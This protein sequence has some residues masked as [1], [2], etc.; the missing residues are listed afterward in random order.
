MQTQEADETKICYVPNKEYRHAVQ[1]RELS[2]SLRQSGKT[3]W[4]RT[5]NWALMKEDLAWGK[6][7]AGDFQAARR[8]WSWGSTWNDWGMPER[9]IA[10]ERE[11][12]P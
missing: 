1:R 12:P 10:I 6:V 9:D 2:P 4:R 7:W 11:V 5:S 8:A 3:L